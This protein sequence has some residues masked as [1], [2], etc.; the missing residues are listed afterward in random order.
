MK[1]YWTLVELIIVIGL[2]SLLVGLIIVPFSQFDK[3]KSVKLSAQLLRNNISLVRNKSLSIQSRKYKFI[4]A[5]A[6]LLPNVNLENKQTAYKQFRMCLVEKDGINYNFKNYLQDS[7]W[8]SL[9]EKSIFTTSET[10]YTVDSGLFEIPAIIFEKGSKLPNIW[11]A[12][13]T[14]TI[15]SGIVDNEEVDT[16]NF[17]DSNKFEYKLN[18]YTGRLQKVKE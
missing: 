5:I 10:F 16:K 15:R 9:F 17:N 12:N 11:D 14:L 13:S 4:P 2:I 7:Q 18:K 6:L 8:Q 1:K 3:E